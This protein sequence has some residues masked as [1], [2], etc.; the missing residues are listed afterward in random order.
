[1]P[2]NAPT[3]VILAAGIGSRYGGLKQIDPVGPHGEIMLEYSIYDALKAG[4]RKVVIVLRP[5]LES[6]F[7]DRIGR[8]FSDALELHYVLQEM[9]SCLPV[10]IQPGPRTKPW[11]TGHAILV[12][13]RVVQEPFCAINADDFYG[14]QAY[15]IM[16]SHFGDG[17]S[18]ECAMVAY[19]LRNTLS[20]YGPVSRGICHS[21]DGYL[22]RVQERTHI[23]RTGLGIR[24]MDDD[25][26]WQ[27]LSGDEPVSMN[28]WGF[29]HHVYEHLAADF[30]AF[31]AEHAA[32][33][34]AEFLIPT[35]VDRLIQANKIQMRVSQS[36]DRWIGITYPGD[37]PL[38]VRSIRDL[39][40]A[41]AYP[42]DLWAGFR[43][44]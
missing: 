3:L 39:I 35:V 25:G 12:T 18:G 41:G 2:D 4:F 37:K 32:Q 7:Q 23:E 1:M 26:S 21:V 22:Q 19:E 15:E 38:V 13:S 6:A 44:A 29:T 33:P 14:R 11:G 20:D 43:E 16:A 9:D 10:G 42:E 24:F 36:H 17:H 34:N 5:E 31:L 40:R 27:P 28:F 8:R 30:R